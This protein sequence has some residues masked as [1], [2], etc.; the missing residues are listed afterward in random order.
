MDRIRVV[1]GDITRQSV[2]AIVN[3]A[4]AALKAGGGVDG[5]IHRAA[6]PDLQRELDGIGGCPTGDCRLS[7]G[8]NLPA[9]HIIH[10]V[11]P[12]WHG[13]GSDEERLLE[14]CY[15]S[16]LALARRHGIRTLAFPAIST[17]IYGFP[18][19]RAAEIAVEA[20][21]DELL[22]DDAIE[23]VRFVVFDAETARIYRA[24]V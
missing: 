7:R 4:N 12:V 16:A 19:Q 6:G 24:L 9:P 5:A 15:R 8:Y 2:D 23:E 1:E 10:C 11:G 20:V 13:G 17:G 22:K 21:R 3:A 14:S 18:K